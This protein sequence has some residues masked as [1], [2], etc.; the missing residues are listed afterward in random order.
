MQIEEGKF[1]QTRGGRKIGP[2]EPT[3][4]AVQYFF[5][6]R[7]PGESSWRTFQPNGRYRDD[8]PC[9]L[10]IVA[11][12]REHASVERVTAAYLDN[13]S[14]D[15]Q[16]PAA[17]ILAMLDGVADANYE[18]LAGVLR[19]AHAHAASGKGSVRHGNGRDFSEQPI[20]E[21]PRLLGGSPE[22]QLYQIMKK[23]QE[24]NGM[25]KRG[26]MEA[27]IRELLGAINYAAAAVLTIREAA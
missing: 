17:A 6:T 25:V 18:A 22:G 5:R 3:P 14:G 1:Y 4:G 23:A 27:A 11:E 16:E 12:W 9:D 19:E 10:D 20:M 26:E 15:Q 21:I 13:A 7:L 8:M 24:A 2:M